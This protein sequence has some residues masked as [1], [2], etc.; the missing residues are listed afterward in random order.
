M[1]HACKVTIVN[2]KWTEGEER[3]DENWEEKWCDG[4]FIEKDFDL[5]VEWKKIY[6]RHWHL[7]SRV[8]LK[9]QWDTKETTN[10]LENLTLQQ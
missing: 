9:N 8:Q 7:S 6:Y 4:G 3:V 10:N 5:H 2:K 1:V